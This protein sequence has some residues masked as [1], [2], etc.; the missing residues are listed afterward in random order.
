M[1]QHAHPVPGIVATAPST[2]GYAPGFMTDLLA[3]D[4]ALA[5]NAARELRIAVF[6]SPVAQQLL[7]LASSQGLGRED[8]SAVYKLLAPSDE[9]APA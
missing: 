7:R 4:L 2:N 6:V 8:F 3:K 1:M 5:V 9:R